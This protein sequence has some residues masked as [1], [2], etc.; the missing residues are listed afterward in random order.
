MEEIW[1]DV[2]NFKGYYKVSNLGN[3]KSVARV[4]YKSGKYKYNYKS[5]IM[6]QGTD[7]K[8]YKTVGLS[9]DNKS[10]PKKV[11]ILVAESFL[12]HKPNGN[13]MVVDHINNDKSDNR[14][15]NLRVVTNRENYIRSIKETK[16]GAVG[17]TLRKN[18]NYSAKIKINNEVF[19]L[20]TFKTV[21]EASKVYN[22]FRKIANKAIR[23]QHESI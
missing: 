8:G 3:V 2:V 14:L 15:S 18:G 1:K 5:K 13:M 21:E 19:C 12:N 7:N 9:K 6:K 4:V 16:S 22:D 11:H 10:F 23:E 17:V 20:G